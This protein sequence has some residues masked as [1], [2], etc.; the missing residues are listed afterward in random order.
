MLS[1]ADTDIEID[2]ESELIDE[3]HH[4]AFAMCPKHK[5]LRPESGR[6]VQALCGVIVRVQWNNDLPECPKCRELFP[7]LKSGLC[8]VCGVPA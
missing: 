7:V 5:D 2:I 3:D 6:I 8:W 4:H 1:L